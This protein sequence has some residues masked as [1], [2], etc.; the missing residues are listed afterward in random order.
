M[1]GIQMDVKMGLKPITIQKIEELV[2]MLGCEGN[3][4][5]VSKAVDIAHG[6]VKDVK[7][8]HDIISR[9]GNHEARITIKGIHY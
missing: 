9:K 3:T 5:G 2:I 4:D 8:G 7:N 1:S 6:L